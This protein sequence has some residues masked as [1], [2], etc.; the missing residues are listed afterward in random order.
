MFIVSKVF[1]T[2]TILTETTTMSI[3]PAMTETRS[4]REETEKCSNLKILKKKL[5]LLTLY[6]GFLFPWKRFF[7]LER[8]DRPLPSSKN[9]LFSKRG[10]MQTL[11]CKNELICMRITKH[12]YINS[13]A[14][15][16]ALKQRFATTRKLRFRSVSRLFAPPSSHLSRGDKARETLLTGRQLVRGWG[17][18]ERK[19]GWHFLHL[20]DITLS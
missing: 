20:K 18:G 7:S 12:F 15:S 4:R 16:L 19:N 3:S 8:P 9:L 6:G 5:L 1:L 11:S 10:L 14:P 2:W 17:G 13:L